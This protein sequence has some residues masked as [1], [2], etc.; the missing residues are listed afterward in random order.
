MQTGKLTV[1]FL[2]L[3]GS[4][5][6]LHTMIEHDKIRIQ[7][8]EQDLLFDEDVKTKVIGIMN[9]KKVFTGNN[10]LVVYEVMCK[11]PEKWLSQTR[12]TMRIK[13]GS[14]SELMY[15]D[16]TSGNINSLV[17]R[18]NLYE[19]ETMTQ[20]YVKLKRLLSSNGNSDYTHQNGYNLMHII[21]VYTAK[22]NKH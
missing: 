15:N 8:L 2:V 7:S 14:S 1:V 22:Q 13:R 12:F 11:L 10:I 4:M 5:L 19:I 6:I 21:G 16:Y 20:G 3:I 17:L 9:A 18:S